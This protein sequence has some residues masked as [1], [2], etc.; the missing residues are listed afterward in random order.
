MTR[1][2][3]R[4]RSRAEGRRHLLG[5]GLCP[6]GSSKPSPGDSP[7]K[8]ERKAIPRARGERMAGPDASR[9]ATFWGAVK[10]LLKANSGFQ[11]RP[12]V[13]VRSAE[14]GRNTA[15]MVRRIFTRKNNAFHGI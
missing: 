5:N 8:G 3:P 1:A 4:A 10:T 9:V 12:G 11:E 15:S 13:N 2:L 14:R 7:L 6:C